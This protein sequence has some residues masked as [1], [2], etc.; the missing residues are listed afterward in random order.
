MNP[1]AATPKKS[2]HPIRD[3]RIYATLAFT[4][5]RAAPLAGAAT[6]LFYPNIEDFNSMYNESNGVITMKPEVIEAARKMP[7]CQEAALDSAGDWG[8]PSRRNG[9]VGSEARRERT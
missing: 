9:G 7:E 8:Q 6:N 4:A 5:L 1:P 3:L 2:S